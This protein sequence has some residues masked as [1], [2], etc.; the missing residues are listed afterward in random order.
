MIKL[1][2]LEPIEGYEDVV[3]LRN[4]KRGATAID[5]SGEPYVSIGSHLGVAL[6]PIKK[7]HD[8]FKVNDDVLVVKDGVI[9]RMSDARTIRACFE[10]NF[11]LTYFDGW[12]AHT[13]GDKCP[14]D[15][16]AVMVE[17]MCFFGAGGLE[18]FPSVI[19]ALVNWRYVA[20][21]KVTG[22]ADDCEYNKGIR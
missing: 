2:L 7:K 8:W 5:D 6:T 3:E 14:V 4:V 22:L 17:T 21:Y 13:I 1:K 19:A 16:D 18:S 11:G 9:C 20:Q 12:Q 15:P 10:N